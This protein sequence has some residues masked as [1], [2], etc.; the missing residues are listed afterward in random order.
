M[1]FTGNADLGGNKLVNV[2]SGTASTDAVNKS[3][4]D[5]QATGR[6]VGWFQVSN[7]ENQT[8]LSIPSN[9]QNKGSY[10]CYTES[11][12]I[13]PNYVTIAATTLTVNT[14]STGIFLM[15]GTIT[16]LVYS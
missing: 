6:L 11:S 2:A 15:A 3:Q 4:L 7:T 9:Y 13:P 1:K 14:S 5:A 16:V 12:L 10:I 8:T